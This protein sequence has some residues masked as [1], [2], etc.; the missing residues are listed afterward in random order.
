MILR[1]IFPLLIRTTDITHKRGPIMNWLQE[2]SKDQALRQLLSNF[3]NTYGLSGLSSALQTYVN[4]N[5]E[6]PCKT[7]KELA[8]VRISEIN[9]LQ[10]SLHHIS[11]HTNHGVY[12]KYGTLSQE[13]KVLSRY[14]FIKCNQSTLVSLHKIRA[15]R[16]DHV[17]LKD[18]T[19][20]HLSR[21]Y[22]PKLIMEFSQ[23]RSI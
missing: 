20:L 5:Q 2:I 21:N 17:I 12:G 1:V 6:Y 9:Y 7:K 4:M 23:K 14:G 22:A 8:K 19:V 10:I 13:S 11:V 15:I 16:H 3:L 18:D